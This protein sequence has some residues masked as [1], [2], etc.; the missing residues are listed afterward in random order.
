MFLFFIVAG[1]WAAAA[2]HSFWFKSRLAMEN[3]E[4]GWPSWKAGRHSYIGDGRC[5]TVGARHHSQIRWID[6]HRSH[7]KKQEREFF[8]LVF[9]PKSAGVKMKFNSIHSTGAKFFLF[10][11]SICLWQ[12]VVEILSLCLQ[13]SVHPGYMA[14]R[15]LLWLRPTEPLTEVVSSFQ[16]DCHNL[17][18]Q[19]YWVLILSY[20]FILY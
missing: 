18:W 6:S 16:N 19:K 5:F 4:C 15:I 13:L 2:G 20:Q 12:L 10:I 14:E 7:I 8:F 11:F 9:H 3:W 17:F 1:N